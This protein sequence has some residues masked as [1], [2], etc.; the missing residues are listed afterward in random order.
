MRRF[1]KVQL[2]ILGFLKRHGAQHGYALKNLLSEHASDFARIKMSNIYYHF[3]KMRE[4]GL[5]DV[6]L[7][8]EGRRPDRQVYSITPEGEA[9]FSKMMLDTLDLPFEFESL[10]DGPLFFCEYADRKALEKSLLN[11]CRY[12]ETAIRHIERHKKETLAH[13]PELFLPYAELLFEHHAVH[14]A[15]ELSWA[16]K[17]AAVFGG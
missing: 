14:Y 10:I 9:A 3:D 1:L 15:A 17:A 12:L 6:T 16:K 5:V 4:K 7:E 2:Y 13:I 11:R 8:K